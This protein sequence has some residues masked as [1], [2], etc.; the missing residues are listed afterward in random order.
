VWI[1]EKSGESEGLVFHFG[2][3]RCSLNLL[4]LVQTS[5]KTGSRAARRRERSGIALGL[6]FT[7]PPGREAGRAG[8]PAGLERAR[9]QGK[10][11]GRP[12]TVCDY[13]EVKALRQAGKSLR[14]IAAELNTSSA[15]IY[16][17]LSSQSSAETISA[18]AL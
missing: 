5:M 10:K 14:T 18:T 6:T 15:T 1:P 11:L 3:V 12:R 4:L 8:Q 17:I 9:K 16:R 7:H 13:H 2:N